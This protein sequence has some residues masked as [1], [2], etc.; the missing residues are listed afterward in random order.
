MTPLRQNMIKTMEL[1]NLSK[2]TQ[3]GYMGAVNGISQFYQQSPDTL[4]K[5]Q[6]E[7]YLLYL[8]NE[9]G[10]TVGSCSYVVAGLRFFY[11]HVVKKDIQID[12]H[13]TTKVDKLPIVLSG[14]QTWDLINAPSNIKHRL[15]LMTTY[16]AGLRAM[17]VAALKIEHIH[18]DE[19]LIE[20]LGGKGNKDRYSTLS[21]RLLGELRDYYRTCRPQTYLF[22]SSH[23]KRKGQQ[24]TYSAMRAIFENA[25]KKT[26]IRKDA[27]I[28]CLRHSFATHLL[29]AGYD[30]RR[31]QVLLGHRRLSTTRSFNCVP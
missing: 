21:V 22:P 9:K 8:K 29:E 14:Q 18:S 19:M 24:L 16:S 26:K 28:H 25:R 12:F 13:V 10:N 27:G 30:I 11:K 4:T 2:N 20:V 15:V 3:K 1:R 7:D 6:I 17:E 31:I 5:E 23:I